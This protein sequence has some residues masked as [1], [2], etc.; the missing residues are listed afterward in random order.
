MLPDVLRKKFSYKFS[1]IL[2]IVGQIITIL[3]LIGSII[4][5]LLKR[6]NLDIT[7]T[8][9]FLCV[10]CLIT[11]HIPMFIEKKYK[12]LI[13]PIITCVAYT[14]LFAN[15]IVGE[16]YRAYD[17][18]LLLDRLMHFTSGFLF[19]FLGISIIC[20]ITNW[21]KKELVLSP[22]LVALFVFCF[23]MTT[24]VVW[25]LFEYGVDSLTGAIM[26]RWNDSLLGVLK[27]GEIIPLTTLP[28]VWQEG[29]YVHNSIRGDGLVDTM[30]DLLLNSIGSLAVSIFAYIAMKKDKNIFKSVIIL[31]QDIFN[32]LNNN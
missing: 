15:F 31:K 19:G 17:T 9:A 29:L 13:P 1:K 28:N 18:S 5:Y 22:L 26:Q 8:H 21:P 23:T 20:L 11:F 30:T 25:E 2:Y 3:T 27:D 16:I 12:L 4:F 7:L 10:A 14:M 6:Q 32:E 24:G